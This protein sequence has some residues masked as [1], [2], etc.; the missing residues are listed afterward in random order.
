MSRG[1][2]PLDRSKV[3]PRRLRFLP[4]FLSK[5]TLVPTV[6][7]NFPFYV[8]PRTSP[9]LFP[10]RFSFIGTYFSPSFSVLPF[11][12]WEFVSVSRDSPHDHPLESSRKACYGGTMLKPVVSRG[13]KVFIIPFTVYRGYKTWGSYVYT[14]IVKDKYTL[15]TNRNFWTSKLR[16]K[17]WHRGSFVIGPVVGETR[18]RDTRFFTSP[19][20]YRT[21]L[22][23]G[24]NPPPLHLRLLPRSFILNSD[25]SIYI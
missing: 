6:D 21:M 5:V 12:H 4:S 20:G 1:R 22:N 9:F 23:V 8:S 11:P 24:L 7:L 14:L 15:F 3:F 19:I 2:C 17:L 13:H 10:T 18:Q 25:V 16:L